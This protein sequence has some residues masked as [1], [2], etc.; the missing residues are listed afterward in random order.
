MAMYGQLTKLSTVRVSG[1]R[2]DG[3]AISSPDRNWLLSED[4]TVTAPPSSPSLSS[5]RGS[6]Q[7]GISV[8]TV[9][10]EP[11]GCRPA[12]PGVEL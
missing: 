4:S 10:P 3:A 8:V 12:G 9:A 11:P 5:I 2:I 7:P 6:P 1:L